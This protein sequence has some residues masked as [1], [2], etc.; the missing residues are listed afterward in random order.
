MTSKALNI[1][2]NQY[3]DSKRFWEE[4]KKNKLKKKKTVK[5]EVFICHTNLLFLLSTGYYF[6]SGWLQA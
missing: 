1:D 3:L 2:L 6:L 4:R 5:F